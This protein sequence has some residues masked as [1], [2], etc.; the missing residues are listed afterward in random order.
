MSSRALNLVSLC[1]FEF[2]KYTRFELL[3]GPSNAT[4]SRMLDLLTLDDVDIS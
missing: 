2:I 3:E 4:A 1:N